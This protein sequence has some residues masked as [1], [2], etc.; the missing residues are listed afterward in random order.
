M[1]T[2]LASPGG[3]TDLACVEVRRL[4][5]VVDRFGMHTEGPPDP[6]CRQFTVVHQPVD[7]HL[8]DPH[9]AGDLRDG[10]ELRSGDL[11]AVGTADIPRVLASRI[12]R[13]WPVTRRH[14]NPI[15]KARPVP[16]ASPPLARTRAYNEENSG[17][18]G[19]T[20]TGVGQSVENR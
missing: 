15:D 5:Q 19:V 20:A 8:A 9:E 6:N 10:E 17:A 13:R 18:D 11:L 7:G 14:R 12:T 4:Q 1:K 2:G 16:A 3:A